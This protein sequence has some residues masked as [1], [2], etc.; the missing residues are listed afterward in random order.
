MFKYVIKRI[1]LLIKLFII[2]ILKIQNMLSF[3]K[4][5]VDKNLYSKL[6][7]EV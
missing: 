3:S 7:P 1:M 4:Q 5:L 6:F 2:N